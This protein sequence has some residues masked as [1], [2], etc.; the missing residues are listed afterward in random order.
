MQQEQGAI[1]KVLVELLS[2]GHLKPI[3]RQDGMAGRSPCTGERID[4]VSEANRSDVDDAVLAAR[5]AL[6]GAWGEL[7]FDERC[8]LLKAVADEIDRRK[9]EFGRGGRYRQAARASRSTG[10]RAQR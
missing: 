3:L 5:A 1:R 9:E 6:R 2:G 4:D 8:K 10:H 7:E